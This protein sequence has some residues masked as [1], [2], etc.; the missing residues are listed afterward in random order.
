MRLVSLAKEAALLVAASVVSGCV[1]GGDWPREFEDLC[2]MAREGGPVGLSAISRSCDGRYYCVDDRGGMLHEAEMSLSESLSDGSF[3]VVRSIRLSRRVDL[4]GCACDPLTGWVWVSDEHDASIR[5]FDTNTGQMVA[6][7]AV[8]EAYRKYSR[9]N[10]S[11]EGLAISPDGLRMYACNEDTLECDGDPSSRERGG[12]VRIQEF[13]RSDA[14]DIWRPS[15]QI[16]YATDHVEGTDFKGAVVSGVSALC[17]P[18]DGRLLVL[19]REM[20]VKK[21]LLPTFRCRIYEVD[22]SAPAQADGTAAKRLVWGENTMFANYEGLCRGPDLSDGSRTLV[23]VSDAGGSTDP[24]VL[25]L[26]GR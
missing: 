19:E 4:E 6:K 3:S 26:S 22:P 21:T 20:S 23:L 1:T 18:E 7:A 8:P 13:A 12:I 5:A 24:M 10:R 2:E 14:A 17:V 15:R 25:V 11:I 9:R 16:R